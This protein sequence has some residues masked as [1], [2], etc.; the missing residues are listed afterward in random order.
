M[1]TKELCL[2]VKYKDITLECE[3]TVNTVSYKKYSTS[4]EDVIQALNSVLH[5]T[6]DITELLSPQVIN[7]IW[8]LCYEEYYK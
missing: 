1:Y 2:T 7:D 8:D 5:H 4:K 6:E 3:V